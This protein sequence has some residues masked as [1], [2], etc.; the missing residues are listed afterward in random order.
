MK[1][2]S[3]FL[4]ISVLLVSCGGTKPPFGGGGYIPPS[5]TKYYK[6]S[7]IVLE[8]VEIGGAN[9]CVMD[10]NYEFIFKYGDQTK[11]LKEDLKFGQKN[12][13]DKLI[14]S[15]LEGRGLIDLD[16]VAI[17]GMI[18]TDKWTGKISIGGGIAGV[19]GKGIDVGYG[20]ISR[21]TGGGTQSLKF[22]FKYQ[23]KEI[24][25]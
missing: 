11:V 2:V 22:Q 19:E 12:S 23:F 20:V 17:E 15:N 25:Y 1:K 6:Y 9:I 10:C 13:I 18:I 3:L 8:S 5:E 14:F 4:L 7:N 24:K 21:N 16:V